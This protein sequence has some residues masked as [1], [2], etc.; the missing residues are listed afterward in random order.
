MP[1]VLAG[2]LS[3][4]IS[5]ADLVHIVLK[6]ETLYSISRSYK[7]SQEELMRYNNISDASKLQAGMRLAIPQPGTGIIIG[8]PAAPSSAF[9]EYTVQQN[10]T[11][12]SIARTRGVTL[13]SLRDINRFSKDHVLKTGEKIRIPKPASGIENVITIRNE[14]AK[15]TQK[16]ADTSIRWPL[17][18]K[19]VLYMNSNLGVLISGQ[20][21]ES[22]KS[23]SRGTVIHASP[24]RGYG[25]VAVIESDGGYKYLYGAFYNLSVMKGDTIEPGTELGKLGIYPASGKPELVL[26]V[27]KNGSPVDPAKA[28]RF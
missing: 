28:P 11:L 16:T 18:S 27:S 22:V 3:V 13:Q 23:L 21:Y 26:I 10:D 2:L 7:V 19:E 15:T 6:G 14:P 1:A 4:N 12:Y 17:A 25:N 24:W 9:T 5:A 20:E 8:E